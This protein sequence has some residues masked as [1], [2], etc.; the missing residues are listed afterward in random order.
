MTIR[1]PICDLFGIRHP[2]VQTGMGWVSDAGLTAAT[3]NAGGLGILAAATLSLSELEKALGDVRER[4]AAPFGVNLRA[5]AP[6][7]PDRVDLLIGEKGGVASFAMAPKPDLIA[8]LKAAGVA[9]V[10]PAGARRHA[11]KVA[12]WGVDAVVVQ[13]A[14]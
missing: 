5:D 14:E 9:V 8:R 12:G 2:I 4:T 6:D 13:G 3:S 7:A 10:P 11:E 1:T